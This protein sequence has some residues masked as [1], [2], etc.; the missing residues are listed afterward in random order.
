M[1]M[2]TN[3]YNERDLGRYE[4]LDLALS[5]ELF[6]RRNSF[7]IYGVPDGNGKIYF[8][9]VFWF[10]LDVHKFTFSNR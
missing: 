5:G 3:E 7:F 1:I 10:A 6:F 9:T 8:L 4:L 2:V